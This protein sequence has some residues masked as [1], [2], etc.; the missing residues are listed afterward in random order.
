[1][2]NEEIL[3]HAKYPQ[4]VGVINDPTY[5]L[6]SYNPSCGDKVSVTILVKN[7]TVQNIQHITDGCAISRASSSMV[8][9]YVKGKNIHGVQK[10]KKDDVTRILGV[11]LTPNRLKCA[12][13]SLETIQKALANDLALRTI[14]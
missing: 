3:D 12:L 4:N 13:I 2:Y 11:E 8:T 1:M 7:D 6:D 14:D 10:M 5:K 9:E